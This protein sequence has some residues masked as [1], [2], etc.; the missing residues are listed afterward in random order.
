MNKKYTITLLL[1]TFIITSCSDNGN[2][3]EPDPLE[4]SSVFV[5][6]EGNFSDSNGSITKYDPEDKSTL[7]QAFEDEN[8]RPMAGLI[9]SSHIS[10]DRI[11]IASNRTDKVEIANSQTLASEGTIEF[12]QPPT[13][14]EIV[15][16]SAYVTTYNFETQND[17]VFMA[18]LS[19]MEAPDDS[20][21]VGSQPRDIVHVGGMLYVSINS[22]NTIEVIDPETNTVERSIT[23]GTSPTQMIVDSEDRIWIACNGSVSYDESTEDDPGSIYVLDGQTGEVL[24]SINSQDIAASGY[25]YRLALNEDAGEAYLLNNGIS[26]IDM[27]NYT[28]SDTKLTDRSFNGIGYFA[29]QDRIYVGQSNGYSQSG[30]ALL[31]DLEGTAVDSFSTGIVPNDFQFVNTN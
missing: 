26:V 6:N 12:S 22:G 31:Y 5:T 7:K 23:V 21:E 24:N 11:Y 27:N 16:N 17:Q 14:V 8:G 19:T 30:Q 3:P 1:L 20:V 13:A 9:Q 29:A 15:E 25:N 2:N 18:D 10:G 4:T 28:L